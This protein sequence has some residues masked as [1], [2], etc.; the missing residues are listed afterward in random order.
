[1]FFSNISTWG[2]RAESFITT[3]K[4][5]FHVM[6]FA[7]TYLTKQN[8]TGVCTRIEVAGRRSF[9]AHAQPSRRTEFGSSGGIL[10]CP[11]LG[12]QLARMEDASGNNQWRNVGD[13]WRLIIIRARHCSY[14]IVVAYLSCSMGIAGINVTKLRQLKRALLFY[15]LPFIIF[16]DW[17]VSPAALAGSGF[18]DDLHAEIMVAP[19]LTETCISGNIIDFIVVSKTFVNAI[20]SFEASS[21]SPWRG[22]QGFRT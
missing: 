8:L 17:N 11:R 13:D 3:Y 9:A 20:V 22:A 21:I 7:E 14:I 18:P 5:D 2:P 10:V 16:A 1:M 12:L 15:R 6:G 4:K 19:G